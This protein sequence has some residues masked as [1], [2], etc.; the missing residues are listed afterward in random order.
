MKDW[1][2]NTLQDSGGLNNLVDGA[3]RPIESCN[4]FD[5]YIMNDA[6]PQMRVAYQIATASKHKIITRHNDPTVWTAVGPVHIE[7]RGGYQRDELF[8][9]DGQKSTLA[10]ELMLQLYIQWK[11]VLRTLSLIPEE[12]PFVP[13]GDRPLPLETLRLQRKSF[14]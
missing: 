4:D 3:G 8:I 9:V 13:D 14:D 5:S 2:F 6:I 12:E 10:H 7:L 1:V 11:K